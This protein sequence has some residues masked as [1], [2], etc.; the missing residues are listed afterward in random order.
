M[1]SRLALCFCFYP[2]QTSSGAAAGTQYFFWLRGRSHL[3]ICGYVN[4]KREAIGGEP[5]MTSLRPRIMSAYGYSSI[6]D[7]FHQDRI[8]YHKVYLP[9]AYNGLS[10]S[11]RQVH[12]RHFLPQIPT[13]P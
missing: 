4:K 8:Q 3:Q 5:P 2:T 12:G 1:S 13:I 10:S 11:L 6:D 9:H 7:F